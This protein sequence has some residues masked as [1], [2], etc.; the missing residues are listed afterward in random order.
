MSD[1]SLVFN[2]VARD[3]ATAALG[4]MKDKLA[5]AAAGISAA[6]A[7]ALGKG[8]ADNL[9]M[10][11]SAAKLT[12]QLGLGPAQAA[13]ASKVSA[14]VYRDA[15]GEST[16]D[17]NEAIRG[18]YQQIGDT[19]TA[20]GGLQGVTTKA[21]A[22]AETMDQ[23]VGGVT[24]AVGQMLK[25]G[26]AKNADEAFDILT[27]GFQTGADKAGDLLDTMNEYGTQ[28]RKVGLDG[29]T[30][31]GLISQG[32][33][34]GAR[35]AD[36]VADAVKEFSIR[37]IDGSQSTAD[38]FKAVGL[39]AK[40]MAS[41][42]GKG[43]PSAAAALDLTLDRLRAMKDPVAQ[44]AA[45]TAL[46]GTQSEDLGKALFA[47]DPSSA[48]SA[49]GQV[50]GAAD[51]MAKTVHDTPAAALEQ[52]K[53]D[54]QVKLADIGGKFVQ[55]AMDHQS[56]MQPMAIT[57]GAIAGAILLVQGATMAWSAA[58]QVWKGIQMASTAA[59]WLWNA[60]MSANP[61]GLIIIGVAAL[62]AGFV[63]LYQNSET[64]RAICT[65]AFSGVWA[66]IKFVW[67]WISNNWKL[68]LGI[69]TGPIGLA[70]FA[71]THY[72]DQIKAGASSVWDWIK[73][74]ARG[75]GNAFSFVGQ[76]IWAPFK[77]AFNMVAWGW[78][79][80]VGGL[81]FTVPDW[82]PGVG[83]RSFHIPHVPM[84]AK[85]G[86]ITGSGDVIVGENGP[87]RLSLPSGAT[88]TPLSRATG[89]G[90]GVLRVEIAGP[91]EMRRLIRLVVRSDG[92]GDA[93]TAF[94]TG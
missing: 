64:F 9:D 5:T 71:I 52:F 45:A 14:A 33:K 19:S 50:G 20:Q 6:V 90:G 70:V 92:R 4:K 85:G 36:L 69:L 24:T 28:F 94:N 79:H 34:A 25:T 93:G 60:A 8:I 84:L 35:D 1:T 86:H 74:A 57:L 7:G 62:I 47:L 49:L 23:D 82:V 83:G 48:V 66:L 89:G 61:I 91:E 31:T 2:L 81:G 53:R 54:V 22:L 39:N 32:L 42:I 75:I 13:E 78:N 72:W 77:W 88:V 3:R 10:S 38:G 18:V 46:F 12:A 16:A 63:L 29:A 80:S 68:L 15:W 17:V 37:A 44:A 41:E 30:A 67:D 76:M 56:F 40:T 55:F 87:E 58:Q 26:L 51:Q 65:A 21:M 73:T 11:S 27:R 59:Q 43:G